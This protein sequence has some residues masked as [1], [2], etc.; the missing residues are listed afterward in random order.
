MR[1]VFAME[2]KTKV[3]EVI[4]DGK[5]I[6]AVEV[7]KPMSTTRRKKKGTRVSVNTLWSKNE[8]R[9]LAFFSKN[10]N[11]PATYLQISRAYISS[12]YSNFQKSCEDLAKRGVL[13]KL[14]NGSFKVS[15]SYWEAVKR[16]YE[17]VQSPFP[18]FEDCFSKCKKLPRKIETESLENKEDLESL[19]NTEKLEE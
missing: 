9:V 10:Y 18:Y 17:L 4:Q 7:E 15:V 16:G 2:E 1:S 19:E 3:V 11:E 6:K 8:V 14:K 5:V 12:S 13:K